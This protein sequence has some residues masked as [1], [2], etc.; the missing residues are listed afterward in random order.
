MILPSSGSWMEWSEKAAES[1]AVLSDHLIAI[2]PIAMTGPQN[3]V[4]ITVLDNSPT[5]LNQE[6]AGV[7]HTSSATQTVSRPP[8]N[9]AN[10]DNSKTTVLVLPEPEWRPPVAGSPVPDKLLRNMHAETRRGHGNPPC[11]RAS[12]GRW[13]AR[14][15][16]ACSRHYASSN[17]LSQNVWANR[18]NP[19]I[20]ARKSGRS[21]AREKAFI[22]AEVMACEDCLAEYLG[23]FPSTAKSK[24]AAYQRTGK[25]PNNVAGHLT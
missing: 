7:S 6:S 20:R 5:H 3:G 2:G 15:H 21:L 19:E 1:S 25:L 16:V 4:F 13:V 9:A 8:V 14:E 24:I 22:L 11:R 23:I 12:S 17:L 10:A 18:Y